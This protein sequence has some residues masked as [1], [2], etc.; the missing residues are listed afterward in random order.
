MEDSYRFTNPWWPLCL[1]TILPAFLGVLLSLIDPSQIK[2][3]IFLLIFSSLVFVQPMLGVVSLA[4]LLHA[5]QAIRLLMGEEIADP[6]FPIAFLVLFAAAINLLGRKRVDL[7][8]HREYVYLFLFL[9]IALLSLVKV[10]DFDLY[11]EFLWRLTGSAIIF[12]LFAMTVHSLKMLNYICWALI[13]S[14]LVMCITGLWSILFGGFGIFGDRLMS[15]VTDPND[16]A[17]NLALTIPFIFYLF[18]IVKKKSAKL[19]LITTSILIVINI[20]YTYSRGGYIILIVIVFSIVYKFARIRKMI[21]IFLFAAPLIF[22]ALFLPEEAVKR[23]DVIDKIAIGDYSG[24]AD[25]LIERY[26][27]LIA[28]L[29]MVK[30][31]PILGVGLGNFRAVS[32]S[33]NAELKRHLPAHNMYVEVC[34]ELGILGFLFFILFTFSIFNKIR[35][36]KTS[37]IIN[38]YRYFFL[39]DCMLISFVGFFVAGLVR[40]AE[41]SME[42]WIFLALGLSVTRLASLQPTSVSQK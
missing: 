41:Y 19:F 27:L 38:T 12:F 5:G 30:T 16:Y 10:S 22:F 11:L 23:M 25:P 2:T 29:N 3:V 7:E 40:N 36:L 17:I 42:F 37:S 31:E 1:I 6:F 32:P 21:T 39:R 34:A 26:N 35:K 20:M 24:Y 13:L 8:F 4:G 18:N 14:T 15:L 33:Y 28:G 9:L